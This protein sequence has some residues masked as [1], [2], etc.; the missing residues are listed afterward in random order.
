MASVRVTIVGGGGGVGSSSAFNLVVGGSYDIALVDSRPHHVTSHLMDLEQ[1]LELCPGSSVRSGD[2]SDVAE[3]D[4]C[5]MAASVPLTVNTSR[6]VYADDNAAIADEIVDR[7]P[8][9][10][11][12][13]LLVVTNPVDPLVTRIQ[14]RSGLD[15]RQVLGYTMNDSLR[16]G[17]G[18]AKAFGVAPGQVEAWVLGEHGESCVP[19]LD[20]V[21]L[22]GE[23]VE[24][25]TEQAARA[26]E[27]LGTWYGRHVALDSG[28]S[29][30]WTSGLGIARMVGAIA[31]GSDALW[32]ASVTLEGEYGIGGVA[33]TVPVTLGP[34]GVEQIHA[35]PLARDDLDALR[36]S[37]ELVREVADGIAAR[38]RDLS[39]LG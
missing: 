26:T 29:S 10:W 5:V 23:Q 22:N 18:L 33:V 36:A 1:V 27:Y 19:L 11:P 17:T 38:P 20:R 15:R 31:Q 13:V 21:T 25:T 3:C 6:L 32:P 8:R 30:T 16:L 37:A 4:V 12:G 35:W 7:I 34:R 9:R 39:R 2:E 14:R 28:R 24:P